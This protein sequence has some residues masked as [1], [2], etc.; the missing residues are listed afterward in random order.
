MRILLTTAFLLSTT[1]S[2]VAQTEFEAVLAG[3]A[4]LPAKTLVAAPADAPE[5]LKVSGKYTGKTP[6]RL[7]GAPTDGDGLPLNGQPLQGFS[8]IK[9]LGD[10]TYLVGTDNGFGAKV[11]SPDAMLM[12]HIVKPNFETGEVDVLK[13]TFISDPDKVIPFHITTEAS[14]TRYLTGAD[15]DLEGF[16][17]IGDKL[18]IGDEFGPYIIAVDR[19]TGK[20]VEFHETLAD[21]ETVRSPDNYALRMPNPDKGLP[22]YNLK[23]SRG[24]EG[25]A[26]SLDG[27][28]LYG[29]LEGPLWDEEQGAYESIDG[30]EASRILEFDVAKGEWSGRFWRYRFEE[31]GHAIGDFNMIDE[32]RGLVIERDGGQG[33]AELACQDGKTE[34]CFTNPARFKRIYMI[35]FAG[36]ENG[37]PVKKIGYID[38]MNIKDP[39][40]LARLGKREDGR[41]TFPFV[42]IENV[43]KVD[44]GTIIVANDNNFPFSKGRHPVEVDNNEF[45]ILKV[46]DFLKAK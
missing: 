30:A 25:F 36:V 42:T 39:E 8:G 38:L 7:T 16:Q 40:G 31:T 18:Y 9:N 3:H 6:Q 33:D 20:V 17:P 27:S 19:E 28:K 24:Y 15:L 21:G 4:V 41:F 34:N 1:L 44:D 29:L 45:M 26:A 23:R 11:N 46:G 12:F 37:Q 35:D 32:T 10:G 43:D 22:D 13:T 14:D 2:S 5:A